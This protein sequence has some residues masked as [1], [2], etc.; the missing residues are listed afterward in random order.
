MA[1]YSYRK[2][3]QAHTTAG[4]IVTVPDDV[5]E[6]QRT[7]AVSDPEDYSA[8]E[9]EVRDA[10]GNRHRALLRG[11]LYGLFTAG[12]GDPIVELLD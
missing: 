9:I 12:T 11:D 5:Y 7:Y 3:Y 6:S 1:I 10:E 8:E 2:D 4:A